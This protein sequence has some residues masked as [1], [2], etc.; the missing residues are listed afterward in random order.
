MLE[1]TPDDPS[2]VAWFKVAEA[3]DYYTCSSDRREWQGEPPEYL[4]P[5]TPEERN[6]P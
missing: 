4:R 6:C 5:E 1:D 2:D 3:L